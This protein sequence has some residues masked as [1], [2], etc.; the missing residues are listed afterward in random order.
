[1]KILVCSLVI[2]PRESFTTNIIFVRFLSSMYSHRN[3]KII[4][5][6]RISQNWCSNFQSFTVANEDSGVFS[7]D[8]S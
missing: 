2:I 8:H 7:C 1:M 3:G 6:V 4:L 5:L